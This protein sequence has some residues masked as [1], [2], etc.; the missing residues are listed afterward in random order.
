[1]SPISEPKDSADAVPDDDGICVCD[2][3]E[4]P[5]GVPYPHPFNVNATYDEPDASDLAG[6]F[7]IRTTSWEWDSERTDLHD[8]LSLL[9]GVSLRVREAASVHLLAELNPAINIESEIYARVL[10][11][12]QEGTLAAL[13]G[14]TYLRALSA[15]AYA[16]DALVK[17]VF[18][19]SASGPRILAMPAPH[20]SIHRTGWRQFA[21]G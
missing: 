20:T 1:M 17:D 14:R 9:W 15:E 21:E 12:R 11:P 16:V 4:C 18:G 7:S 8:V 13:R 10:V 5:G 19:V 3:P 2:D 6:Y